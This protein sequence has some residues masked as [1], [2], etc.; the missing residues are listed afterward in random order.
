MAQ[1]VILD[2]KSLENIDL[3]SIIDTIYPVGAVYISTA[4]I[5]PQTLFGGSWESIGTGRCLMGVDSSH[6]A[7]TT[8]EAGLPNI[9]G[10]QIIGWGDNSAPQVILTE[11]DRAGALGATH[12][13]GR[14]NVWNNNS[15][16][17]STDN[18]SNAVTF[19]ASRS[20]SIYGNSSTV[21][22]PAYYVYMWRRIG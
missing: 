3:A 11:K 20:N 12:L 21:Q 7:G 16:T 13:G 18:Y 19:N 22:P 15:N 14:G 5:S 6:A 9:T 1:K 10:Q 8:A 2:N 17:S 4:S